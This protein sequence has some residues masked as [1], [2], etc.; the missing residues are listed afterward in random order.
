[1]FGVLH[2]KLKQLP[3]KIIQLLSCRFSECILHGML[4]NDCTHNLSSE[5]L[6]SYTPVFL[7]TKLPQVN[8]TSNNIAPIAENWALLV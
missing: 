2:L 4:Q 7:V 8:N 6:L 1:M 3:N 5:C